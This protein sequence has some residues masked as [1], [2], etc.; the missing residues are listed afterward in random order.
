[1]NKSENHCTH[2]QGCQRNTELTVSSNQSHH[3]TQ[4][5]EPI[6]QLAL[7]PLWRCL[8]MLTQEAMPNTSTQSNPRRPPSATQQM[9]WLPLKPGALCDSHGPLTSDQPSR[10][11][12]CLFYN[13]KMMRVLILSIWVWTQTFAYHSK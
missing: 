12:P 2:D 8:T 3:R 6:Y 10:I 5:R 4:L 7:S 9:K 13:P 11:Q 1:M